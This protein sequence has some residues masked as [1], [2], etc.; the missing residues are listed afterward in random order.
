[1]QPKL[2]DLVRPATQAPRSRSTCN[3]SSSISSDLQP[4][5]LDLVRPAIRLARHSHDRRGT[6][7]PEGTRL[8]VV[9]VAFLLSG[10]GMRLG[11]CLNPSSRTW[12][13]PAVRSTVCAPF[14]TLD[15]P[16]R[17]RQLQ[18]PQ[19]SL[20]TLLDLTDTRED[21]DIQ[22]DVRLPGRRSEPDSELTVADV[23]ATH[24]GGG[25][26]WSRTAPP[27]T[28]QTSMS[29]RSLYS[30]PCARNLDFSWRT[31]RFPT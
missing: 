17:R 21:E 6:S 16:C 29:D 28:C 4:K 20:A 11:E 2:R 14:A 8:P 7:S 13:L 23:R 26:T 24:R 30:W 22:V 9:L 12:G 19:Q 5:L 18:D 25:K 1:M 3:P 27:S 10:S 15:W 31:P